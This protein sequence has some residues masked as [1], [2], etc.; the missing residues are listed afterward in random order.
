MF[1]EAPS[2]PAFMRAPPVSVEVVRFEPIPVAEDLGRRQLEAPPRQLPAPASKRPKRP[3]RAR[4]SKA[5]GQA[6]RS[7]QDYDAIEQT[8][9][10]LERDPW[11]LPQPIA[12]PGYRPAQCASD[13]PVWG[14]QYAEAVSDATERAAIEAGDDEDQFQGL[15]HAIFQQHPQ[16]QE[17][18]R[19]ERECIADFRSKH[20]ARGR[21]TFTAA[22]ETRAALAEASAELGYDVTG[23]AEHL[24]RLRPSGKAA[25]YRRLYKRTGSADALRQ[26]K[27]WEAR[28]RSDRKGGRHV[29]THRAG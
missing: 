3:A 27:E 26:A 13:S 7:R 11:A 17:Y 9:E 23:S 5:P 20:A 18:V 24:D 29:A 28:V 12:G 2:A 8:I 15:R 22:D 21:H 1:A 4:A 14:S 6:P 19:V 16:A 10:Q 25:Y